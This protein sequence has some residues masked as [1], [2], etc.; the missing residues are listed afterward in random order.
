MKVNSDVF[1]PFKFYFWIKFVFIVHIAT[2]IRTNLAR[3]NIADAKVLHRTSR[4]KSVILARG[5]GT[6]KDV[7]IKA[8]MGYRGKRV[9]HKTFHSL[10]PIQE[11][12]TQ[13]VELLRQESRHIC[14]PARGRGVEFVAI[15]KTSIRQ[16]RAMRGENSRKHHEKKSA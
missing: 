6:K 1:W 12:R 4:G 14:N 9:G 2:T 7:D 8:R 3:S 5:A 11:T 16:R 10:P 13:G 15:A